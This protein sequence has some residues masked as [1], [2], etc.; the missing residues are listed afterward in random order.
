MGTGVGLELLS[1]I[2]NYRVSTNE[3]K[4]VIVLKFSL[5]S[6]DANL[7]PSS[8]TTITKLVCD[9]HEVLL[10]CFCFC[11]LFIKY[12]TASCLN[13]FFL[14]LVPFFLFVS[15]FVCFCECA[16]VRVC[17]CACI[18]LIRHD[19]KRT[20]YSCITLIKM[21]TDWKAVLSGA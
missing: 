8:I 10:F 12:C 20:P 4:I 16:C 13:C 1:G 5:S 17:V 2:N 14:F 7:D 18:H 11:F 21:H 15:L 6:S 19:A 3:E 9:R